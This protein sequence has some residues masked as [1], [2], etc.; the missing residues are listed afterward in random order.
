M[1]VT[2]RKSRETPKGATMGK[3]CVRG[4]LY[5]LLGLSFGLTVQAGA[6]RAADKLPP[7]AYTAVLECPSGQQRASVGADGKFSFRS[8]GSG[9]CTLTIV[10]SAVELATA[11]DN[12]SSRGTSVKSPRESS[13]GMATGKRQHGWVMKVE[14]EG[15]EGFKAVQQTDAAWEVTPAVVSVKGKAHEL[16]GHVTLIK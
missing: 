11:T 6:A 16:K 13:T 1:A 3:I 5:V 4:L 10:P 12:A 9:E 7:N 8:V 14:L 2:G 15:A